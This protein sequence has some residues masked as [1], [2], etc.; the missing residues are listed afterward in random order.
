M[1]VCKKCFYVFKQCTCK[2]KKSFECDEL[3]VHIIKS[4][5]LKGYKTEYCCSGHVYSENYDT[6]YIGTYILFNKL[7]KFKSIPKGFIQEDE[8]KPFELGAIRRTCLRF[9]RMK[10]LDKFDYETQINVIMNNIK[11]LTKW[12]NGL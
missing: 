9:K 6:S 2:N 10:G 12:V 7:Y 3:M 1:L 5:N 4:L 11:L 8:D